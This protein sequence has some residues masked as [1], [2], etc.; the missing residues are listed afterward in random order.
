LGATWI[1]GL[2]SVVPGLVFRKRASRWPALG[3][4]L[5]RGVLYWHPPRSIEAAQGGRLSM[6]VAPQSLCI[7]APGEYALPSWGGVLRVSDI[8]CG[9]VPWTLLQTLWLKPRCGGEQ[10]QAGPGRPPR[11]LKKQYQSRGVPAWEREG[12]LVF[13]GESLVFAPGLG[14]DSRF[15]ASPGAPQ[16]TLEWVPA[17]R[18]DRAAT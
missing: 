9:G 14:F 11:S 7:N 3:V 17:H 13:S 16:A 5:Y 10:F 15:L 18:N 8:E 1:E 12:P 2:A 4:S 6:P